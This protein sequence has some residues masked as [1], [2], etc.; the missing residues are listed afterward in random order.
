M[1]FLFVCFAEKKYLFLKNIEKKA[2]WHFLHNFFKKR[3]DEK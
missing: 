1:D 3:V 2:H